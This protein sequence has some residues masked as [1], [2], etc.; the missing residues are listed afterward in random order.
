M[1]AALMASSC[2][3]N[4]SVPSQGDSQ[5]DGS[6][7][8]GTADAAAP[9]TADAI[10][11]SGS[12][13]AE[14]PPTYSLRVNLGGTEHEGTEYVGTWLADDG[15]YCGGTTY[16][17]TAAIHNTVDDPLFQTNRYGSFVCSLGEGMLPPGDY[18]VLLLFGEVYRGVGCGNPGSLSRIYDVWIEGALALN[19]FDV[20]SANGGCVA[21]TLSSSPVPVNRLFTTTVTD[22]TLNIETSGNTNGLISAIQIQSIATTD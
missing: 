21:S 7:Q 2:S 10:A 6:V 17:V 1:A 20:L 11:P 8:P 22:G 12:P 5:S 9:G 4:G 3:F 13:D 14:L 18:S 16:G 15:G 19:N